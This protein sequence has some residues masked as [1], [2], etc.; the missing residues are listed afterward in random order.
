MI[1]CNGYASVQ[2]AM[3]LEYRDPALYSAMLKEFQSKCFLT[4]DGSM[5]TLAGNG[6]WPDTADCQIKVIDE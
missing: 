3:A 5:D 4:S 2:K 1:G 6:K